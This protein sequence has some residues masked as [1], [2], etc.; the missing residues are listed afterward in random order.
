MA[1]FGDTVE[2][3]A[4]KDPPFGARFSTISLNYVVVAS[5]VLKFL[6]IFVNMATGVG[7][8]KMWGF[9]PLGPVKTAPMVLN[10][11]SLC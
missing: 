6:T 11:L 7:R 10:A 9:R 3:S 2:L 1:N 8:R 5:F 4:L